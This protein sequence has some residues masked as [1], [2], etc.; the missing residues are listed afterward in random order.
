[1]HVQMAYISA[2][3][4]EPGSYEELWDGIAINKLVA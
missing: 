4:V 1:M 2:F 3:R